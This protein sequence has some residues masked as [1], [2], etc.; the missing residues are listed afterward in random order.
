MNAWILLAGW[1]GFGALAVGTAAFIVTSIIEGRW[2]AARVAVLVFAPLLVI[3]APVLAVD[4]PGRPWLVLALLVLGVTTVAILTLPLGQAPPLRLEKTQERIDERDA[5][6]HRFYRLRP[7]MPEFDE[8]YRWNPEKYEFDEK[9]RK[10]P[11]LAH[12]GTGTYDPLSSPFTIAAFDVLEGMTREI[13]WTPAPI[14][15]GPLRASPEEFTRRVKGFARYLGADLVG[16]TKLNPAYV[17]SRIGRSPGKW[18]EAI[19]LDH[20]HAI[21]I[22]VEMNHEMVRHAPK[23]PTTTETAFK[24]FEAAKI[25]M[26]VARYINFL[27][28]E[29]RA[30]VDGN[31]RVMCV[32]IAC[33]AGLGELGRLGLLMTPRFGPSVRLSIVTTN[34]PLTQD[35][36]IH[37]GV[38]HFCGICRK[39]ATNCPSQSVD[40][41]DRKFVN[42]AEKWQTNRD[43]CYRFWRT[44]GTDCAVCIN[45]CP[46]AHPRTPLHN[47]V[48]WV[49]RRNSP[50][51]RVA[52]WGD[53]LFYGRQPESQPP[54]PHWHAKTGSASG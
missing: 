47:A 34:L 15:D 5:V 1:V 54:L 10:L 38:Q 45:V 36:P 51:R 48:R 53:D 44:N 52:L 6:F 17:Y 32:P 12:P 2:R 27:G 22:A 40:S 16:T 13:E 3:L 42:G 8:Y 26:V 31:Y 14:E 50:A 39:C 25:A 28:Y 35:E 41:G 21:A 23:A 30:H 19:T 18:G 43:T 24:Y 49:V 37:F 33:D 4:Y 46:Y 11:Q 9:V 7:G 20:E 29:A